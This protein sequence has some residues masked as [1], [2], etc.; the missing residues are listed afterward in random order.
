MMKILIFSNLLKMHVVH[1]Y[2]VL[3]RLLLGQA[4]I[5]RCYGLQEPDLYPGKQLNHLSSPLNPGWIIKLDTLSCPWN[6]AAV[7]NS[8]SQNSH[9]WHYVAWTQQSAGHFSR[10]QILMVAHQVGYMYHCLP[11]HRLSP[12]ATPFHLQWTQVLSEAWTSC[13]IGYGSLQ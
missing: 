6:A 3:K 10:N 1:V 5:P 2:L 13:S 7:H 8:T 11:D 4:S 9:T 12:G